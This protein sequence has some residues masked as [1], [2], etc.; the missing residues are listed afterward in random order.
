MSIQRLMNT[1]AG[2]ALAAGAGMTNSLQAQ[3][4]AA[5]FK[6]ANAFVTQVAAA[7]LM[8]V[9]LGQLA[10]T[11]AQTPSVKQF[12][13]KMVNDHTQMQQTWMN[14]ARKHGAP[15]NARYTPE[16]QAEVTRLSKLS[17]AEFERAY[18]DLMVQDHQK[19]VAAFQSQGRAQ[20][21]EDVRELVERDL[22]ALQEHYNLATR[23]RAE[24]SGDVAA[25]NN[26]NGQQQP[27]AQPTTPWGNVKPEV[28]PAPGSQQ[29]AQQPGQP[30]P[31]NQPAQANQ[32]NAQDAQVTAQARADAKADAEFIR[33][34]TADHTLEQRLAELAVR[35]AQ[36]PQV[37]Q[38]AQ[39]MLNDH[40]AM[41]DLWMAAAN[42][43]GLAIKPGYGKN[44]KAKLT[45]LEKRSGAAF[46]R[47]YMT[48]EVRNHKDYLDYFNREGQAA[49]SADVRELVNRDTPALTEH[50]NLAK[51]IGAQV[52]ADTNVELRVT[53]K[54]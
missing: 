50:F 23:I 52:N 5:D 48:L 31:Q 39:K 9:R 3:N 38:Y 42:K 41:Q 18:M 45:K 35:R 2:L 7:N 53:S 10:N 1:A 27:G 43:N 46:D 14:V 36:N 6:A 33:D 44:H 16:Q 15:F 32:G 30:A 21:S 28:K 54:R 17:G 49:R 22:P 25:A 19:N 34:V 26:P 13:S 24:V 47:E 40:R 4:P 12:A 51:R 11:K 37:K 8:E 20:R 29:P